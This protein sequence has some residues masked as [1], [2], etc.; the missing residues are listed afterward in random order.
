ML[1][2]DW[3]KQIKDVYPRRPS[4]NGWGT[5][6][7]LV[8]ALVRDGESFEDIL[9]AAKD[10]GEFCEATGEQYIRMAQTFY[11]PGEWWQEDYFIPRDGSVELTLDQEA[12]NYQITR[13]PNEDDE[14]LKVRV[15]IAMTNRKYSKSKEK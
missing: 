2:S 9:Q 3:L 4:G 10:Y 1:P 13:Q 6:K 11:G 12:E 5:V 7:R 14:S 8:P 15:G